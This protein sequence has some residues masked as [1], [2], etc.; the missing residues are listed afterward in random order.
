MNENMKPVTIANNIPGIG[1]Y[2]IEAGLGKSIIG[3]F[4]ANLVDSLN[5]TKYSKEIGIESSLVPISKTNYGY[6]ATLN[7][8]VT[9]PVRKIMADIVALGGKFRDFVIIEGGDNEDGL[10]P[11]MYSISIYINSSLNKHIF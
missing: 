8:P 3:L 5:Y 11:S 2:E 7:Y 10:H 1:V 6:V 9:I 4:S